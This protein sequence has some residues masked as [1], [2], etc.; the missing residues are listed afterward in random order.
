MWIIDNPWPPFFLLVLGA[1]F[2]IWR[3]RQTRQPGFAI[4]AGSL[5]IAA[6]LVHVADYTVVTEAEVVEGKVHEL[7]AAFQAKDLPLTLGFLAPN[8]SPK[9]IPSMVKSAMNFV[10]IQGDIDVKDVRVEMQPESSRAITR[11]RANAHVI[12]QADQKGFQPSRWELTWQK[13][14]N[15]DWQVVRVKRLDPLSDR[16]V[17]VFYPLDSKR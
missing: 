12:Y 1:M 10:T 15:S 13:P 8:I 5:L 11:F 4:A 6:G 17:S 14:L 3:W 16:E 9:G 7:V 2:C